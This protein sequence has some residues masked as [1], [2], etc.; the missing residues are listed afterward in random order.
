[1]A[2]EMNIKLANQVYSTLCSALDARKWNYNKDEDDLTV[3]FGVRGDDISMFFI[4]IVDA[5][6]QLIRLLSPMPYKMSEDNR[7]EGAIATCVASFGMVDGHFYC[8]LSD[9]TIVFKLT[10]SFRESIIGE[11]LVQ[12]MIS[13]AMA[14]VEKYNDKFFALDKGN[15]SITDFINDKK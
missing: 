2:D 12:Y 4:I 1:M 15:I 6:R 14:M 13:C 10:A 8:D 7:M 11:G 9:G 5:E 3:S